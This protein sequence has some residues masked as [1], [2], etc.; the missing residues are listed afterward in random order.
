MERV[1]YARRSGTATIMDRGEGKAHPA[2]GSMNA[3]ETFFG[4]PAPTDPK[5]V[6]EAF[7]DR[8]RLLLAAQGGGA[9]ACPKG[10][11]GG[12]ARGLGEWPISEHCEL[13]CQERS[14]A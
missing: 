5:K 14:R 1:T 8:D 12:R 2:E 10:T 11:P 3:R 6:P 4:S 13:T 7:D 9:E